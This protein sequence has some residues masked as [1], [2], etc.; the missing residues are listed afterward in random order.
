MGNPGF[1]HSVEE[2]YLPLNELLIE[3][4]LGKGE[5]DPGRLVKLLSEFQLKYF[6]RMIPD[7]VLELW[8]EG[9]ISDGYYLKLNGSGGGFMLGIAHISFRENL[10]K[11]WGEALHWIDRDPG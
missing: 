11:E 3:S 10:D 1:K 6:R 4:I 8:K 7:K 5:A 2:E 9:L